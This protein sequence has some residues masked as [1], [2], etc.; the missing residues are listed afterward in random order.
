[1]T[2]LRV[3][4]S[5]DLRQPAHPKLANSQN[6]PANILP[7]PANLCTA[8]HSIH[9]AAPTGQ[10]IKPLPSNAKTPYSIAVQ[11]DSITRKLL[12]CLMIRDFLGK[13][14]LTPPFPVKS[15]SAVFS[16]QN[17]CYTTL[18]ARHWSVKSVDLQRL[19]RIAADSAGI[20]AGRHARS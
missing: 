2:A 19:W 11:Q 10:A 3:A 1:M 9:P 7:T 5:V 16:L 12:D 18:F 4:P 6:M 15:P 20:A 13:R 8:V 14:V 17:R